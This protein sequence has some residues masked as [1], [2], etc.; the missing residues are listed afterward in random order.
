[1]KK[2]LVIGLGIL[3]YFTVAIIVDN[4]LRK[5]PEQIAQEKCADVEKAM[6]V[7][8]PDGMQPVTH[9]YVENIPY[10]CT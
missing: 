2:K 7:L 9:V 4:A 3:V 6:N 5:S 1:M 8:F 10:R